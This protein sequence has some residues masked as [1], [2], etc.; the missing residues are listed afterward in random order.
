MKLKLLPPFMAILAL[1]GW[2]ASAH[3]A[4]SAGFSGRLGPTCT[5]C[6]TTPAPLQDNAQAHLEGLPGSW[7][8]GASYLLHIFVTGGPTPLPPP[9][10][11]GG[12]DLAV[13]QGRLAPGPGFEGRL[14]SPE[15]TEIT[16]LPAGAL[17]RFWN[18]SWTAPGLGDLQAAPQAT[19]VWLAVLAADGNHVVATNAS[20]GGE[21]FDASASLEAHVPASPGAS[22]AWEALPLSPPRVTVSSSATAWIV[23]GRQADENATGI[24]WTLDGG[25]ATRQ[26]TGPL[27]RLAFHL[28]PGAHRV[29][30]HSE[31]EGRH[32]PDVFASWAAPALRLAPQGAW[33]VLALVAA[34]A[35]RR[36]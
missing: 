15:A 8:P 22:A 12:F 4:G 1:A 33:A 32:S 19:N 21:R 16:Y 7:M 11:Q 23:D 5:A 6:H 29:A 2:Q 27:W 26:E 9:Q 13:S 17:M 35:W 34:A 10:P 20:D 31:G 25:P 18:V 30:V 3:F 24:D 14:R 28:P 36:P